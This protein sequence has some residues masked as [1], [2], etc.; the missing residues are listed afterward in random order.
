MPDS[1]CP[2]CELRWPAVS[3]HE[4]RGERWTRHECAS[5]DVSFW[6]PRQ[7]R[8]EFYAEAHHSTYERRRKGE[9]F[10]RPR[11]RLFLSR[12]RPGRLLD[13]GCGEGSFLAAAQSQGYLVAGVDLDPGNIQAARE[14]GLSAV[15]T[16]TLLDESGELSSSVA[17][18]APFDSVTAFEVLEHQPAP[19]A[20]LRAAR[21]LLAGGGRL[22][23]S[24][25]NRERLFAARSRR[26]D[27]G[28][29]PPHHFLWF[30]SRGL[31]AVLLAAGFSRIDVLPVPED[32]V[33][34]FAASIE[35]AL[36]G[37]YTER[38]KE[39]ARAETARR[40]AGRGGMP[41]ALIA[42]LAKLA[43]NAPF[44]PVAMGVR[45]FRPFLGR[46]LYFEASP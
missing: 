21:E 43:K 8:P 2:I 32:D 35:N 5:C 19:V 6:H 27:D 39:T 12:S 26:R 18:L 9:S 46:A 37:G 28:D 17:K 22:C 24:V 44:V 13:V 3:T 15:T 25:P 33:L 40:E 7:M 1:T 14:R 31:R 41:L 20:F 29:F 38:L 42:R 16:G 23:G 4:R 36:L 45:A 10:L 11:H 34:A 30:S